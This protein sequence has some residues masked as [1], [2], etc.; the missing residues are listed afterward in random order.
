MWVLAALL[1]FQTAGPAA[2]GLKA[3]DEGRYDA[4]AQSFTKAIEA[5]PS[6]YTAHFN[7]ALKSAIY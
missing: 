4:A 6:D 5:D 3:L 7:L 2:D 1:F